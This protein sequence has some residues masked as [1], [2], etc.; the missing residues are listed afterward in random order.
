MSGEG[1]GSFLLDFKFNMTKGQGLT[2]YQKCYVF[3]GTV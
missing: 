3:V 2:H 1:F